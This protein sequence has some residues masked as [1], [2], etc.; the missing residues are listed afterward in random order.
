MSEV[1]GPV[2]R[3][4]PS[5]FI[6]N[7]SSRMEQVLRQCLAGLCRLMCDI[8]EPLSVQEGCRAKRVQ[9]LETTTRRHAAASQPC[10]ILLVLSSN[11][12]AHPPF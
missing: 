7:E 10:R 1:G 4:S 11:A 5:A 6:L 8:S 3:S 12:L 9:A 2:R